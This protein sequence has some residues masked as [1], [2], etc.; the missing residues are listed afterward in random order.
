MFLGVAIVF[1]F[2]VVQLVGEPRHVA[3]LGENARDSHAMLALDAFN[4][5]WFV[6]LTC[7]GVHL[8]LLGAMILRS[9]MGAPVLGVLLVV[10][11]GAYVF[12]TIAFTLLPT[13]SD[14]GAIFTSLVAFPAVIAEGAFTI[15]LLKR[16]GKHSTRH[17]EQRGL[18]AFATAQ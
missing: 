10:A 17:L 3:A 1:L 15:W 14:H 2:A 11:G 16:A 9:R 4:A 18:A 12:D 13:Y 8:T 7:F 5:T 6:G